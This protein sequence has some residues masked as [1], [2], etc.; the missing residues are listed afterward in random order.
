MKKISTLMMM[1]LVAML[2]LSFTSCDEDDD[3]A[4]TLE[5][6]W[7]GNMYVS[8]SYN[9]RTY[10][11]TYSEICF[12]RDPYSYSS[13]AG[14]WIDYYSGAPWKYIANHITWTVRDGALYVHFYEENSDVVIYDYRL[15]DGF[16]DGAIYY[17]NT[18]VDFSLQHT[19]SP[20][21]GSYYWYG[22]DGWYDG[23]DYYGYAKQGTITTRASK[24]SVEQPKRFFRT[25]YK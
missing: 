22:D 10:D 19:S 13:G 7:E 15:S 9:G 5:G 14:Y 16:F 6:T 8:E 17:G 23:W 25:N 18:R 12:L 2:T 20:N 11:A 4:Y 24:D 3:I 1:T 21:W